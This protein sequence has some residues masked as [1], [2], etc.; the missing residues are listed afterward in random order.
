MREMLKAD[1]FDEAALG[2]AVGANY[3]VLIYDY[4]KMVDVLVKRDGMDG[5][6]AREYLDFNVLRAYVGE[7][8]PLVLVRSPLKGESVDDMV[9][10]YYGE[11]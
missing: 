8:T 1:G 9:A 7:G 11:A 4:D 5:D 10:D 3:E 2:I 6:E